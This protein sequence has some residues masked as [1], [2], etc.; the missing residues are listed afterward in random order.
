MKHQQFCRSG[1]D[2]ASA[3]QRISH[4]LCTGK[5]ILMKAKYLSLYSAESNIAVTGG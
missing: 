5:F 2:A 4:F 3:L 1:I